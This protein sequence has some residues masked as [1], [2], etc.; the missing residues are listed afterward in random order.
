MVDD[1][2]VLPGMAEYPRNQWYVAAFGHE[3]TREPLHRLLCGD[4]VVLY[5]D[6]A[7][8]P[9]ALF[10]RCPHRGMRL[11]N[12]GM[13]I[14]DNIQCNYHGL[15][16]GADGRCKLIPSGGVPVSA[17]SVHVYPVEEKSGWIWIWPGD[18]KAA[19]ASLIPDHD[20]LGLTAEGF[21]AYFGV[22]LDAQ[23][24]YLYSFENLVDATPISFL[25]HGLIDTGNVAS[26][27]Y[28]V[29]AKD[30]RVSMVR[31]F[32][33]EAQAPMLRKAFGLKGEHVDRTLELRSY[34]PNVCVVRNAFKDLDFPD[35]PMRD[36]RLVFGIT[37][38]GPKSCHQFVGVAQNYENHHPGLFDDLRHLLMEDVV[39]LDDVQKLFDSL[40]RA[41]AL[42]VSVRSD[43][44]AILTRRMISAQIKQERASI[45]LMP[46]TA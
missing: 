16:F 41:K 38:A 30:N 9:V 34:A 12:G 45:A 19:D 15:Q 24:N 33:N 28:V 44:G 7:G 26:H 29:E 2:S 18:S 42:E 23:S 1:I 6:Q 39:A 4:P 3:V 40:P 25:H 22:R 14:G 13:L 17:L 8:K 37:P 46:E 36:S 11:S 5:R 31:V 32:E 10:D 20:D 35:Q 43:E 21:H 27:P